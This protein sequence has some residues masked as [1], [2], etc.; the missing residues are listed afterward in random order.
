[1]PRTSLVGTIA[2]PVFNGS[3]YDIYFG[4]ADG[5]GTRLFRRGASQ[6]AFSPDGS[7]I[8]FRSWSSNAR[9][10]ISMDVSGGNLRV[11]ANFAEDGLPTWSADSADIVLLARRA[12]DRKSRL[13]RVSSF[14]DKVDGMVLGEGEYPTIGSTGQFVFKGWGNTGPGLRSSTIQFN[15]IF[16]VTSADEDTAPAPSPDG[17]RIAFMSRRDGNWDIYVI[18]ADGSRLQRLI[19][20]PAD[21]GLPAWSPDGRVIAFASNR[22]GKWG[23]W[24]TTPNG[25]EPELLFPMEGSPD[26]YVGPDRVSSRGWAEER[27]SWTE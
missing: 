6:P 12:G 13:V 10:V 27:I 3:D 4:Q 20:D 16:P 2:Y 26:G 19:N 21:D 5:S 22:D 1:V 15:N 11:A 25:A 8:A 14:Q 18:D 7:R 24:A 23:V 17:R 9:S